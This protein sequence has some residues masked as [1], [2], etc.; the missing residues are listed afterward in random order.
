MSVAGPSWYDVHAADVVPVYEAIDPASLH[1]WLIGLLP[2]VP[3]LIADIGA[4]SGRDAAWFASLGHEVLAVEPSAT[5][6]E[7]GRRLHDDARVRWVADS[8][9]SLT[10]TLRLGLTADLVHLG[11]VWQHIS[12]PDRPRAFRKLVGLLR[13][14][15]VLV[16]TLR[17]GPDDGRG[18]HPVSLD[19]I[20][21]LAGEH[22][23]AV[24]RVQRSPDAMGRPEVSWTNVAL[25]VPDDGTGSL[26]LLRHLVL[27]D[28][29]SS[30][31]KLGLLRSLCRIADS[32]AGLAQEM[33]DKHVALPLGIVALTWLRLYLPM[34]AAN[35]PQA[36]GNRRGAEGLGFAGPGFQAVAAG[37]ATLPGHVANVVASLD[38]RHPACG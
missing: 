32:S 14:G 20:E 15:G 22:G 19:E 13:S 33:D 10:A 38:T 16:V 37:A 9:P 8:L 35:L 18:M 30:T 27:A 2:T 31:Y 21:R 17:H 29:K 7:H 1:A 26:P 23:L 24:V 34:V 3:S 36:P 25:R 6:R 12:P 28:Q 11:A 5:M 4:G